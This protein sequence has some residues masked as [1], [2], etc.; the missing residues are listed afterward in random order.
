M[1]QYDV[2]KD[3]VISFEEFKQIVS[4]DEGPG[5]VQGGS[6]IGM[7]GPVCAVGTGESSHAPSGLPL[8]PPAPPQ[9]I[10]PTHHHQHCPCI[11]PACSSPHY[12]TICRPRH[13]P[14]AAR[15][16]PPPPDL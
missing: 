14:P 13:P 6:G 10:Q 11:I 16:P 4:G 15:H 7:P 3:G 5:R 12:T 9:A 1:E 8:Q 2:N